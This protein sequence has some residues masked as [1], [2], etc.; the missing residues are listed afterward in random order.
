MISVKDVNNLNKEDE[1]AIAREEARI[2]A[3]LT[4]RFS[5]KSI[6]IDAPHGLNPKSTVALKAKYENGG[7]YIKQS[8]WRNESYW[9]FH[10]SPPASD[11]DYK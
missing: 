8:N 9:E 11:Y 4:N 2:D 6:T 3:E 5:G 7:W 10:I 1:V